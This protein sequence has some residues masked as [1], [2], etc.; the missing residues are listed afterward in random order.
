VTEERDEPTGGR[1][2]PAMVLAA[3]LGTRLLPLTREKPKPLAWLGD[4]PQ[5]EHV[6]AALARAGAPRAIVNTHHLAAELDDA[7]AAA[8]PLPITRVHEPEIL[9][10]G[11]GI[12]NARDALGEGEV[13]VWNAD[14][15]VDPD[16][17]ALVAAHRASGA[18]A[19]PVLGPERHPVGKGSVGVAADGRVVRLRAVT[20]GE[21]AFGADYAG[22]AVLGEAA[23]AALPRAGCLVGDTWIPMMEAGA[24]LAT[25]ALTEPFLDT[26]SLGEYLAA[27]LAWLAQRGTASFVAPGAKVGPEVRLEG[28]VVGPGA[29]VTGVGALSRVVVW[30]GATAVA[31]LADAVVTPA[32]GVVPVP[33]TRPG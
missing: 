24:H 18:A 4:R 8:Q 9:G 32:L 16:L 15:V 29:T 3:G 20:R 28:V 17:A 27:N 22:I 19:T 31:P 23:R 11:G 6:L 2:P 10:T 7:W 25:F 5:I 1:L 21:E 30:P 14:I 26:G 12:A 33:A 13:L